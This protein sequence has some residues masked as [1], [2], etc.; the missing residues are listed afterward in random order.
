[1]AIKEQDTGKARAVSA[2]LTAYPE[3]EIKVIHKEN[4]M[5]FI[6]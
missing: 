6:F 4:F 3:A 2:F 5:E 1:L